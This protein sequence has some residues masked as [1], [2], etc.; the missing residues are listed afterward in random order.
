MKYYHDHPENRIGDEIQLTAM[1]K[2]FNSIGYKIDYR[3]SNPHISALSIFPDNLVNFVPGNVNQAT[4]FDPMN[5]WFWSVLLRE[6]GIYTEVRE[7]Y[8]EQKADLDVVFI[9]VLNP[10]YNFIRGIKPESAFETLLELKKNF[11]NVRMVVDENKKKLFEEKHPDII[12]SKDIHHAFKFVLRSKIF[13]GSDTGTTHY[14]GAA[15][16]P[17]M[18]LLYPDERPAQNNVR[19]HRD[20]M[21]EAY[22]EPE[23][24]R[25]E[26]SSTPCCNPN[27]FKVIQIENNK[28]DI[29]TVMREIKKI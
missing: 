9:P 22:N 13:L 10:P 26:V 25:I 14:A 15:K 27:Q 19:W 5:L 29:D 8:D 12:Y 17:R 11:K 2:Y 23:L 16:H 28:I 21:A 6:K 4:P 20:V 24:L 1:L 3:D 7:K 18:L